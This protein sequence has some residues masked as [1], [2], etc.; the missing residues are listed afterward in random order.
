[1]SERCEDSQQQVQQPPPQQPPIYSLPTDTAQGTTP[2]DG[3]QTACPDGSI[4]LLGVCSGTA[5]PQQP[6]P[7]Q[8]GQPPAEQTSGFARAMRKMNPADA[9]KFNDSFGNN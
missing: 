2:A 5:G 9:K 4:A 6:P 8:V 3:G 1:M 7:P